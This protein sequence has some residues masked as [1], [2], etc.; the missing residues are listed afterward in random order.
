M[1]QQLIETIEYRGMQIAIKVDAH[2][3]RVFGQADV[4]AGD[5][6]KARLVLGAMQQRQDAVLKRVRC[7]AK[8]KVDAWS[9]ANTA[10]KAVRQSSH[11]AA[12][13]DSPDGA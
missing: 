8:A 13:R 12:A 9:V 7:L 5:E 11:G 10:L 4:C 2:A 6:F 1:Q 3:E